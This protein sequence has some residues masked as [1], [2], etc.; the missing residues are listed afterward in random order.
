MTWVLDPFS[1]V[2]NWNLSAD[3]R[4]RVILFASNLTTN[5]VGDISVEAEDANGRVYQLPVEHVERVPGFDWLTQINV[6]LTDELAGLDYVW[7]S[8]NA[9]GSVSNKAVITLRA[10]GKD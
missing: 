4:T 5:A 7:V 10:T 1:V 9:R 6:R 8:L 2:S 3:R